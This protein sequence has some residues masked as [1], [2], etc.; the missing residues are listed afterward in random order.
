[1]TNSFRGSGMKTIS[2]LQPWAS[3]VVMGVKIIETRSWRTNYRGELL[4]HAS[5]GKKGSVLAKEPPFKNYIPDFSLLPFSAIIGKVILDEVLP[6]EILFLSDEHLNTLTLEQK[7]FGD[8]TRGRY[9]WLLSGAVA[10]PSPIYIKGA[11]N[12]WE[13]KGD[14]E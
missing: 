10:L 4:I 6:V 1:M 11:L 3:L 2:L 13:Y 14:N 9:A 5:S 8:Y 7:A 12:L